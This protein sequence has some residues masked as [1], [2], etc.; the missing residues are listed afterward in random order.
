[1][2]ST[3]SASSAFAWSMAS[4]PELNDP[5]FKTPV[6]C[7]WGS[8]CYYN[9]CCRFVHPGEEGTGRKL[10]PARVS[11]HNQTGTMI[12]EPPVVRLIGSPSFY[13]RRRKGLSWPQW[14]SYK[15]KEKQNQR[16]QKPRIPMCDCGSP[17]TM[18]GDTDSII[19]CNKCYFEDYDHSNSFPSSQAMKKEMLRAKIFPIIYQ[20]F[21]E[22]KYT[23]LECGMA[24]P[25]MSAGKIVTKLMDTFKINQLEEMLKDTDMMGRAMYNAYETVLEEVKER[26]ARR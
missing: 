8:S 1:M 23:I 13:E 3:A 10:F 2:D 18:S 15:E 20:A 7:S 6:P 17:A 16:M 19:F 4:Q 21:T 14:N 12:W 25:E 22:N 5:A 24:H 26:Y 11:L 9:G